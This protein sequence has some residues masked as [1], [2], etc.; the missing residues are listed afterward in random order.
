MCYVSYRSHTGGVL[1]EG[2]S[3]NVRRNG[4]K[5]GCDN[6]GDLAACMRPSSISSYS[7]RSVGGHRNSPGVCVP[8][9]SPLW[10]DRFKETRYRFEETRYR[11]KKTHCLAVGRAVG[12]S[13]SLPSPPSQHSTHINKAGPHR[14]ECNQRKEKRTHFKE[15]GAT[16]PK[17]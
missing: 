3:E 14:N 8:P 13:V 16:W 9:P 7:A 2:T 4:S 5:S 17:P 15:K 12:L 1:T 6:C 11:F 10:G